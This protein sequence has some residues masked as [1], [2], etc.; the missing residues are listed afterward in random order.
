ANEESLHA[1]IQAMAKPNDKQ[2]QKDSNFFLNLSLFKPTQL[3]K[4]KVLQQKSLEKTTAKA[5][6]VS[7]KSEQLACAVKW[8]H[9]EYQPNN[10][11]CPIRPVDAPYNSS[12]PI[13]TFF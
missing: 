5:A 3:G 2:L 8:Q 9:D 1:L 10:P 12:I 11:H 4:N 13:A 6:N 7:S